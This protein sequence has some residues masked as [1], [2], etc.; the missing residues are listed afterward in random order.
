MEGCKINDIALKA[1]KSTV[2]S[3]SVKYK[4][5]ERTTVAGADL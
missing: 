2:A 1:S 3:I 4:T 5:F